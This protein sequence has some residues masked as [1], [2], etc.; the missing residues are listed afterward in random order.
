MA[1]ATTNIQINPQ[2]YNIHDC[3]KGCSGKSAAK[4]FSNLAFDKFMTVKNVYIFFSVAYATT[5]IQTTHKP[6]THATV[7]KG[8]VR[9]QLPKN[10]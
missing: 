10:F 6:I 8:V 5:N 1:Y 4:K 7:K 3:K 2:T 9:S